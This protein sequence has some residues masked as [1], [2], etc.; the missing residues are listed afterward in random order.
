MA[1]ITIFHVL[2]AVIGMGAALASDFLFTFYSRDKKLD[3]KE[4]ETLSLLA[5][6]VTAGLIGLIVTGSVLFFSD[7]AYYGESSKFL[8]KMTMVLV[9]TLNGFFLHWVVQPHFKDRGLL[10]FKSAAPARRLAFVSGAISVTSWVG[11]L[12]MGVLGSIPITYMK[13]LG[14]YALILAFAMLVSLLVERAEFSS[15]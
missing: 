14:I 8:I 1:I 3:A 7:I 15:Q 10:T 4:K 13:A 9:L 6:L 12:S 11:A 2:S 5:K